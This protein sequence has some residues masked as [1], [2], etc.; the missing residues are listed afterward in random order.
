VSYNE[1]VRQYKIT[2]KSKK[3]KTTHNASKAVQPLR[4]GGTFIVGYCGPNPGQCGYREE[5]EFADAYNAYHS[6]LARG[7]DAAMSYLD[8]PKAHSATMIFSEKG[9]GF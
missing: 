1:N 7:W 4:S 9:A 8:D 3:M 2:D 5:E 6:Y